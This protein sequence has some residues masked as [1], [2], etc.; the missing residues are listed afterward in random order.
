MR[1]YYVGKE[2]II[3][4][5]FEEKCLPVKNDNDWIDTFIETMDKHTEDDGNRNAILEDLLLILDHM[6]SNAVPT[7]PI[8]KISKITK[9]KYNID[10]A[11]VDGTHGLL[12]K[13][14]NMKDDLCS[15][16]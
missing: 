4:T 13:D 14:L 2:N 7:A 1:N 12:I 11:L 3:T 15:K 5:P 10:I 6:T 8:T 16:S 9:Q